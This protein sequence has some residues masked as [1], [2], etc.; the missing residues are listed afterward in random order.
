[1]PLASSFDTVGWFARDAALMRRLA[2]VLLPPA[3]SWAPTRLLI[4]PVAFAAAGAVVTEALRDSVNRMNAKFRSVE[5]ARVYV[6][7]P[8][9]WAQLFRVLQGAE[10]AAQHGAWID[11]HKPSFGPGVHERFEWARTIDPSAVAAA[12]PKREAIARH[13]EA[14]LGDNALICLPAAPGIAPKL[15]TPGQELEPFRARAFVLLA[16][17][18][19][20]SLPQLTLPAAT[21]DGCPIGLSLIAPHGRDRALLDWVAAHPL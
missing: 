2:D 11:R 12:K 16:I 14:L 7:D 10:V 1:V 5:E 3:A 18:G 13:M 21:I 8:S 17:A 4:A 15:K 20:A 19:L 9:E 6:G